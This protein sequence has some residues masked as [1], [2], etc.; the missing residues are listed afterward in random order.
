MGDLL[1][2]RRVR[3]ATA[4]QPGEESRPPAVRPP[5]SRPEPFEPLWRAVLGAGCATSATT[6]GGRWSRPPTAPASPQYLS[7]IERGR[8]EPSS[9]I[10]AAVAGALGLSVLELGSLA[11]AGLRAASA[12]ASSG[13]GP[14]AR[15]RGR[16]LAA[17]L[18]AGSEV[19]TGGITTSA[20]P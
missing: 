20:R 13:A 10:V 14:V 19:A 9:E 2:F 15:P 12:P 17:D 8:K 11:L 7:E 1:P 4:S 16:P 5:V 6:G 3:D 18:P